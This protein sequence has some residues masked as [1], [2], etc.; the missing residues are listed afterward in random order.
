[1]EQ[2][3]AKAEELVRTRIPG[4]RKGSDTP[5]HLHSFDVR[6]LL[7]A[8]GCS[9]EVQLAGLLHDIVEDGDTALQDLRD[10][11]FSERVAGLV[12]LCSHDSEIEA[13]IV[14]WIKMMSRLC[15]AADQ[16]AW[17]V[18]IADITDNL[19]DAHT[20]RPDRAQFMYETKRPL[21]LALSHPAAGDTTLWKALREMERVQGS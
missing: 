5:A 4:S 19:H 8:H 1:M 17:L 20:M 9:E 6:D 10:A 14:R 21:L 15:D 11:G 3:M 2:L 18:K 13:G 7:K 16:D 12:D